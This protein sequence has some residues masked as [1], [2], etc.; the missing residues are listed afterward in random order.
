VK[1]SVERRGRKER[2]EDSISQR[3]S[4]PLRSFVTRRR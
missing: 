3:P 1:V 2:K 4:Q